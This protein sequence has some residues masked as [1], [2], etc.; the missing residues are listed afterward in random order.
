MRTYQAI[1]ME[2]IHRLVPHGVNERVVPIRIGFSLHVAPLPVTG[3]AIF[4]LEQR[5]LGYRRNAPS[6]PGEVRDSTAMSTLWSSS[7][8]FETMQC[9][10]E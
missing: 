8:A 1:L 5:L 4:S 2:S 10:Q 9:T 3:T 7:C 6:I